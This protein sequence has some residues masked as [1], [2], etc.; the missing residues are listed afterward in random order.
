[1]STDGTSNLTFHN[2]TN[3][4]N[5]YI[6]IK[7]RNSL[8]TWSKLPQQFIPTLLNYDFTTSHTKAYG[9]NMILVDESPV[10]FGI[11]SGDVNQDGIIDIVDGSLIDNDA[12]NFASGYVSTDLNGD[13]IIDV[14]D[15]VYTDNNSFNFIGKVT[16]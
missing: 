9:N 6:Q 16:P 14:A 2:A 11:Y 1:M 8:E 10:K 12:F 7:H 13:E 3:E 5:Y 15:A 4:R